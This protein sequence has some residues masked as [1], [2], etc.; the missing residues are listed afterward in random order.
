MQKKT[1][2]ILTLVSIIAL[3]FGTAAAPMDGKRV[4]LVESRFIDGKGVVFIF[5]TVGLTNADLK[6]AFSSAGSVNCKF[7][8]DSRVACTVKYANQFAGQQI[9][10]NLAGYGF[11]AEVPSSKTVCYG[12]VYTFANG[13]VEF[14]PYSNSW[15]IDRELGW[16]SEGLA[17]GLLLDH[18]ACVTEPVTYQYIPAVVP[19]G[20]VPE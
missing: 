12:S 18:N 5:E 10:I 16:A 2:I 4:N 8:D 15:D 20:V 19:T 17:N 1:L 3:V 7:K 14:W 9:A 11:F 13:D 6:N